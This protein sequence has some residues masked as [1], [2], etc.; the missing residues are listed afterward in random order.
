[1]KRQGQWLEALPAVEYAIN[2]SVNV[3]TG[4]SPFELVFGKRPQLF[5]SVPKM[6]EAQLPVDVWLEKQESDWVCAQDELWASR[7]KQAVQHNKKRGVQ[8]KL[9]ENDW[10]LLD[11]ANWQSGG[12]AAKL[13]PKWEGPYRITHLFNDGQNATLALPNGDKRHPTVHISKIKIFHTE[14]QDN[15]AGRG[16][17]D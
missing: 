7:V 2:S 6:I 11:N 4:V 13:K 15:G 10:V 1:M 8:S 17:E 12:G 5:P 14:D 3:S 9:S 16:N